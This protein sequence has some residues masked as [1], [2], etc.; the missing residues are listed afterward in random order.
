MIEDD[1]GSPVIGII[2]ELGVAVTEMRKPLAVT[3]LALTGFD[4]RQVSHRALVFLMTGTAGNRG[5]GR[6]P[7]CAV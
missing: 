4:S 6:T 5:F 2:T 7:D 3:D 1:A